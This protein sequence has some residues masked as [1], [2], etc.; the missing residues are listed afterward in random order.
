MGAFKTG[1]S[2]AF[3]P[4]PQKPLNAMERFVGTMRSG[5]GGFTAG[6]ADEIGV[7]AAAAYEY[8]G[9]DKTYT[10]IYNDMKQAYEYE[11]DRFEEQNPKTAILAEVMGGVLTGGIGAGK[12]AAMQGGKR[13][14]ALA[15]LGG[16]YGGVSGAGHARQGDTSEGAVK[17]AA[18]GTG[19]GLAVPVAGN[20]VGRLF[21]KMISK[22][23]ANAAD[24]K[25]LQKIID[26][27]NTPQELKAK[28]RAW[29][30][31][32]TIV[33]V[34]GESVTNL[35]RSARDA[36]GTSAQKA[37]SFLEGRA[38]G[39]FDR[40]TN[41]FKKLLGSKGEYFKT[42][43]DL[44]SSR[45]LMSK[46]VYERAFRM[47]LQ[48]TP[49]M[50]QL[51]SR[52]IMKSAQK[53]A[54]KRAKNKGINLSDDIIDTRR[55]DY[56]KKELDNKIY[57]PG[58][59]P[60]DKATYLQ[61]KHDLLREV[62]PQNPLY[63]EARNIWSGSKELEDAAIEGAKFM[64]GDQTVMA[65]AFNKMSNAEQEFFRVGAIR[66]FR[67]SLGSTAYNNTLSQRL[68]N[69]N[70]VE[71]LKAVLPEGKY[72]EFAANLVKERRITEVK[73]KIL[74]GSQTQ[75]K[76]SGADDLAQA[77]NVLAH[78]AQ[79]NTG[80]TAIGVMQGLKRWGTKPNPVTANQIT[81][82]ITTNDNLMQNMRLL[83]SLGTPATINPKWRQL[84]DSMAKGGAIVGGL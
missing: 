12:T 53:A 71:R 26:D 61:L 22:T 34:A 77:G 82:K 58:I 83:E 11:Q 10:D 17:G 43:D 42:V 54:I 16:G 65:R 70:M 73:N 21:K 80:S 39:E 1:K 8:M 33:D 4:L 75:N 63:K 41:N 6:W 20:I 13:V 48:I 55:I 84:I 29:G 46:K 3:K 37:K 52:P 72:E 32:G 51:L 44:Q 27:G 36:V 76:Q 50:E 28:L 62:D 47:H 25:I 69:P 38:L 56:I 35:A 15:A 68:N 79:G 59:G 30:Q 23:P 67:Q 81:D 9:S 45:K 18:M 78:A 24:K 40:I 64:R 66:G 57:G 7:G 5:L 31:G 74:S 14:A 19:I 60:E 49:R 2:R